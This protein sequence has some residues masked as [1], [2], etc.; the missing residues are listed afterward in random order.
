M[1]APKDDKKTALPLAAGAERAAQKVVKAKDGLYFAEES[2]HKICFDL[3][4]CEPVQFRS[5]IEAIYFLSML[6]RFSE[7]SEVV[8][9]NVTLGSRIVDEYLL[10]VNCVAVFP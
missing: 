7:P 6:C 1:A 8:Y 4:P 5:D 9:W 2:A 3:V 10:F